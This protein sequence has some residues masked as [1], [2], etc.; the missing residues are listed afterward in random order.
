MQAQKTMRI[1]ATRRTFQYPEISAARQHRSYNSMPVNTFG[2][3]KN[4]T[5]GDDAAWNF[6]ISLSC[7]RKPLP[8]E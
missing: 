1:L 2:H 7:L 4:R 6:S 5:T 3:A 8:V